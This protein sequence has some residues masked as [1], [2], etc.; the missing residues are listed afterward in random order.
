MKGATSILAVIF[1]LCASLFAS[2]AL[3]RAPAIDDNMYKEAFNAMLMSVGRKPGDT[4]T[5]AE[6]VSLIPDKATA[7]P[8]C[9]AYDACGDA[10]TTEAEYM[11]KEKALLK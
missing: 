5:V 11:E 3:A 9:K 10:K 7:E 8:T 4:L 1:V 2:G 6:C